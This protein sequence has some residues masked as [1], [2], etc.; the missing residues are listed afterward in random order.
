METQMDFNPDS[1]FFV[2]MLQEGIKASKDLRVEQS[3]E[4]LEDVFEPGEEFRFD[5]VVQL[6]EMD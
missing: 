3:F 6:Q 4:D 5:A 2:E 1:M